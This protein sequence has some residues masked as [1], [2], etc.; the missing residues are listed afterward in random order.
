MRNSVERVAREMNETRRM[1]AMKKQE[2]FRP[3]GRSPIFIVV[4]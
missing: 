1:V 2:T 4:V 3:S